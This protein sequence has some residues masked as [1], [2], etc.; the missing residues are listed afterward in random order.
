MDRLRRVTR[1]AGLLLS[2][3]FF[4]VLVSGH[5]YKGPLKGVCLPFISCYACPLAIFSCPIGTLQHFMTIRAVPVLLIGGLGLLGVAVGRMACGWL[6]PFGLLQDLL[7]KLPTAKVRIPAI[8]RHGKYLVL[9]FLV[10]LIPFATGVP[11]F[12]KLCPAG[13]LSAGLPWVLYNPGDTIA[14]DDVGWFF[15]IKL[16]ILAAFVVASVKAKRPFCRTVCPLGAILALFNPVSAVQLSSDGG[17]R[18][19]G[20]C[21][22][23]CPVDLQVSREPSSRECIRCLRCTACAHVSVRV[24]KLGPAPEPV[25]AEITSNE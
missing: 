11:W 18:D 21:R 7:H 2:N 3:G 16:L 12:S 25:A 14:P 10:L 1:A 4:S 13:T 24:R 22:S 19:C 17:C 23:R 6:C 8:L 20:R 5:I 15:L 9:V